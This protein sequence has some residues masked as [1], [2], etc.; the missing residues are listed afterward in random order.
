[1]R[2]LLYLPPRVTIIIRSTFLRNKGPT[3]SCCNKPPRGGSNDLGL[4]MKFFLVM[5]AV[6]F[7]LALIAGMF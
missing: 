1:M 2:A 5:L 4:M 7:A 6:I 3:M